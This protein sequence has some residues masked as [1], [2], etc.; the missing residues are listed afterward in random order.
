M[1]N[2]E[3]H[4]V[5]CGF[6]ALGSAV[7]SKLRKSGCPTSNI[8]VIEA[9]S[10]R[11]VIAR[12]E[13]YR[14]THGDAHQLSVLRVSRVGSAAQ[15][16]ICVSEKNALSTVEAVRQITDAPGWGRSEGRERKKSVA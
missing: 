13:G 2:S 1:T 6:G 8:V 16:I 3:T 5:V 4:T 12:A 11:C 10:P 15:I 7:A 9:D 14:V